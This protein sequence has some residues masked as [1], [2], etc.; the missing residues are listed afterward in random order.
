[1]ASD[2]YTFQVYKGLQRPLEFMGIKGRFL[3]LAACAIGV[4]FILFLLTSLLF[5]KVIS[6]IVMVISALSF[7]ITIYVKQKQ[8]LHSK[9]RVK[10]TFVYK[11][12]FINP[13][14]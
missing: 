9:K 6:F 7:L 5:S 12:I 8:G 13:L 4:S 11:S 10:A 14:D 3:I 2:K 1:M